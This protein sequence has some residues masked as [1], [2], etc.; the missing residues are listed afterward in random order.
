[1][2]LT[3]VEKDWEQERQREMEVEMRCTHGRRKVVKTW[4]RSEMTKRV[5]KEPPPPFLLLLLSLPRK[6]MEMLLISNTLERTP[7]SVRDSLCVCCFFTASPTDCTRAVAH[8]FYL[9]TTSAGLWS[10][11]TKD[12]GSCLSH[13]SIRLCT[14]YWSLSWGDMNKRALTRP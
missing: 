5:L 11:C 8:P 3:I 14:K 12:H 4:N 10:M 7:E 9:W 2:R 1:M 6:A 13:S